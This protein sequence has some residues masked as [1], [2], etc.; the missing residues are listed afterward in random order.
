MDK[1]QKLIE[2]LKGLTASASASAVSNLTT[3]IEI[4][5]K[6]HDV[7]TDAAD[8]TEIG[9]LTINDYYADPVAAPLREAVAK[10][11]YCRYYRHKA[12]MVGKRTNRP[13]FGV[14]H[15]IVGREANRKAADAMSEFIVDHVDLLSLEAEKDRRRICK[16]NKEKNNSRNYA[17]SVRRDLFIEATT[18]VRELQENLQNVG[19]AAAETYVHAGIE[20]ERYARTVFG[21]ESAITGKIK[22]DLK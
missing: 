20:A 11:F 9:M 7:V 14:V 16:E 10:Y 6:A 12:P 19:G 1:T 3:T 18:R 13:R 17:A 15:V 21:A 22:T 8:D 2:R 5:A 4:V